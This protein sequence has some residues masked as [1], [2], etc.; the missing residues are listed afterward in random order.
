M[1]EGNTASEVCQWHIDAIESQSGVG[2]T[3]VANLRAAVLD[4]LYVTRNTD[5]FHRRDRA[6]YEAKYGPIGGDKTPGV[7][8]ESAGGSG[9]GEAS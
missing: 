9:V 2:P 7:C 6:E 3:T 1:S 8:D 5:D 4:L